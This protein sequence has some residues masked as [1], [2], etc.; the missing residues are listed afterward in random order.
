MQRGSAWRRKGRGAYREARHSSAAVLEDLQQCFEAFHRENR[1]CIRVPAD[2]RTTA[3]AAV[4]QG[5]TP[6]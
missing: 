1:R 4:R 6:T 2:M 3:V 5:V